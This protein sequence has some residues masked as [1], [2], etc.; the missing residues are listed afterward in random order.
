[1]VVFSSVLTEEVIGLE[2]EAL[3]VVCCSVDISTTT[4]VLIVWAGVVGVAAAE[5]CSSKGYSL[6]NE[7]AAA[8]LEKT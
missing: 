6:V 8:E 4:V 1:M 5:S 3:P 7:L 2:E